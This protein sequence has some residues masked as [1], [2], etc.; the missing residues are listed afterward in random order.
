LLALT[1]RFDDLIAQLLALKAE[2]NALV[3]RIQFAG[4]SPGEVK[5]VRRELKAMRIK[6][7]A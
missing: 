3:A 2:Q 1:S 4:A 7:A 6:L 5:E